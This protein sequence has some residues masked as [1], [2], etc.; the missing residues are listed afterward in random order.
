[1]F[2]CLLLQKKHIADL[3]ATVSCKEVIPRGELNDIKEDSN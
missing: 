1:M 2:V 3:V